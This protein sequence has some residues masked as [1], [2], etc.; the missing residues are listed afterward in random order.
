MRISGG[1]IDILCGKS[2]LPAEQF[3]LRSSVEKPVRD[4][5]RPHFRH[6]S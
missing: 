3:H 2:A 1:E 6:L 4:W 5:R